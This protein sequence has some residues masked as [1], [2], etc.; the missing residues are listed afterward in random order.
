[1][2]IMFSVRAEKSVQESLVW[3][4]GIRGESV[5]D[6]LESMIKKEVKRLECRTGGKC[7]KKGSRGV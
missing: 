4:A 7:T 2:K 1:M 5:G 3:I 6:V